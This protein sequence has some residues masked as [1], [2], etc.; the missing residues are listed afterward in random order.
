MMQFQKHRI[1]KNIFTQT[2]TNKTMKKL[3][4]ITLNL[5]FIS[6]LL[7]GAGPKPKNAKSKNMRIVKI[8]NKTFSIPKPEARR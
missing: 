7:M 2:V 4:I 8:D 6:S 1:S 3:L 5:L